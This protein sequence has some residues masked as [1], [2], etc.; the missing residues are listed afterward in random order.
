MQIPSETIVDQLSEHLL[1]KLE[2]GSVE[3][4]PEG[5]SEQ[6]KCILSCFWT[7][8]SFVRKLRAPGPWEVRLHHSFVSS[9]R[10]VSQTLAV[11]P[12]SHQ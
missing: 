11:Y 10:P 6:T 2:I 7:D 9:R 1:S 5:S 4:V 8:P 3:A 12:A